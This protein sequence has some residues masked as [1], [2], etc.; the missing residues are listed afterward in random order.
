MFGHQ[1]MKRILHI[2]LLL[3]VVTVTGCDTFFFVNTVV[4]DESTGQPLSDA[5]VTLVLDKGV[6]D[7]DVVKTT[8][9]NGKVDIFINEPSSAWATLTVEKDGYE[10]WS[11][12]FRGSPCHEFV[13][14][15]KQE[16]AKV[17]EQEN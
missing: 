4:T 14:R 9:T 10:T 12:Q 7:P 2:S 6:E 13:I 11:T 17:T 1:K 15:L 3:L 5:T 16:K 8:G